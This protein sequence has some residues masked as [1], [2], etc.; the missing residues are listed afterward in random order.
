M[1]LL[2]RHIGEGFHIALQALRA[3]PVRS[4][5]TTLGIIIGVL[6]VILMITIVQGLNE[7]FKRQISFI[8]SGLLY[9]DKMPWIQMEDYFVYRNRPDITLNDYQAL[10]DNVSL[11]ET[12]C[13]DME[14]SKS[15]SYRENRLKRVSLVGT[16]VDYLQVM[17]TFPKYGRFLNETDVAHNRQVVVIGSDVAEELFKK[18]NPIGRRVSISGN[19]FRVIGVLEEQGSVF[20]QSL[21]TQAIIPYGAFR[22][23]FGRHHWTSII[24]KA[25]NPDNLEDLKYELTGIMRRAR[26]LLPNQEDNFSINQQSMLMNLYKQLTSGVYAVGI[27]IGGISLIVGGIGIMNIM[28]VSVTERTREIGI[29]KA[30]GANRFNIMWQFLVEAAVICSIGG[31]FG[32][33]LAYGISKI[34]NTFLPASMPIWVAVLGVGF[35]A[36]VGIFFGLWPAAKAAK[37]NPIEALRYE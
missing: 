15:F 34:I 13:I 25:K 26:S 10:K 18:V 9:V 33:A 21:D 31:S 35:S 29:R 4:A 32:V 2:L 1:V 24:V 27:V 16:E 6:T 11:A 23:N 12:V 19:K 20:G 17:T 7:S 5:L 3:N 37:L 14:T 28:L 22:K 8:G 36:L 30:I